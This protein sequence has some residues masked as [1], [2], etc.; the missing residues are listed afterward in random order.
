M[1]AEAEHFRAL[2]GSDFKPGF[3]LGKAAVVPL[4]PL[5]PIE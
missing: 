1:E 4:D 5:L 2:I 3:L